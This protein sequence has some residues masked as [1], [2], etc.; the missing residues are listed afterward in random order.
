MKTELEATWQK[1]L[2]EELNKPYFEKLT[3]T[4]SEAYRSSTVY[5]LPENIF[6]AFNACPFSN[7][8]VVILGQDPY[9]GEGQA[10]G[11]SFSVP[12]DQK[13]PPSLRN[14]YKEIDSDLGITPRT[15]GDLTN[16][17]TQGVL[18]LNATLTV[19]AGAPGSHQG[20]GW[21]TFTDA[22]IKKISED[23]PH[24]VFLLWGKYAEKKRVLIDESKH[25]VLTAPHPSPFSAHTGF[26][27]CRHFSKTNDYLKS[28]GKN[29]ITW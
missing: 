28:H 12:S 19:Q 8:K 9:H 10:Q 25:L 27:G 20:L 16:W 15:S 14:I 5:P 24:V 4:I 3:S 26:F 29:Q 6:N 11:L 2:V 21:E 1:A 13:L 18:L 17:A 7:I 22:I 23:K